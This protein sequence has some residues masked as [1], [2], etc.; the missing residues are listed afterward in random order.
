MF[1]LIF[2]VDSKNG[3]GRKKPSFATGLEWNIKEDMQHF[4]QTTSYSF[5][6]KKNVLIMG[7]NTAKYFPKVTDRILIVIST[8][9]HE[10]ITFTSLNSALEYLSTQ[11]NID[12]IFVIGGAKLIYESLSHPLLNEI[13]LT[14]L[15]DDYN[16][17]IWLNLDLKQYELISETHIKNLTFYK[18]KN[19]NK[20]E[21]Q[22]LEILSKLIINGHKR[23]TRNGI[24]YSD[25]GKQIIFDLTQG[26]PILTTKKIFLRGVFEELKFFLLGKTDT[27]ELSQKGVTI[28]NQNTSKE[29]ISSVG[30]DYK[31]GDMGPMYGF[32]WRYYNADYKG[33]DLSY[34]GQGIDQFN[35]IIK[36]IKEDPSSRRILMTTYN[37]IQ[38]SQGVLY[39]CH[40]LIIQFY[41]ENEYLSCHMYQRS[42]DWF[43]GCPFN[44]SSYALLLHVV[45]KL[46]NKKPKK[47]MMSF[48]DVHLYEEHLD[49][50]KIQ[51]SRIPFKFPKLEIKKFD[52]IDK[53]E[54]SDLKLI[55]YNH[56][57]IIK[58]K[59]IA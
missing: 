50:A 22:Y 52:S 12:K 46:T 59:M 15:K 35:N 24:T 21:L 47:L 2:C 58:A 33:A 25:F 44:I 26:F 9:K 29:F 5:P 10:N 14:K 55:D 11:Q 49:S 23:K 43:L 31:V 38:A 32:Q 8:E 20:G 57:D 13:Y 4:K 45:A 41:V 6:G 48:G 34:Q 39:P 18:F 56:H 37:P 1:N 19:N 53:L 42:A 54:F 27:N 7:H 40:G 16:C 3:L 51:I 30:L 17:D 36:L 28:W